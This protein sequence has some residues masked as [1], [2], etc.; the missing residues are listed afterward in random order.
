M[1]CTHK[2]TNFFF[3]WSTHACPYTQMHTGARRDIKKPCEVR[4]TVLRLST[5]SRTSQLSLTVSLAATTTTTNH[6]TLPC[7]ALPCPGLLS[8]GGCLSWPAAAGS[9]GQRQQ[10]LCVRSI[11]VRANAT[12]FGLVVFSSFLKCP[13]L[14]F[15]SFLL[16]SSCFPPS[17][18]LSRSH[19]VCFSRAGGPVGLWV[20]ALFHQPGA[21][22]R[23]LFHFASWC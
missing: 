22:V 18:S 13:H 4:S 2:H 3:F 9:P 12:S 8:T 16:L 23:G 7:P 14:P 1:K 11:W 19:S 10:C 21:S 5:V 20:G 6:C 15:P 17:L